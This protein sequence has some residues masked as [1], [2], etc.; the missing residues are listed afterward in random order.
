M[1]I[2]SVSILLLLVFTPRLEAQ[3]EG[4]ACT[5]CHSD[6][7]DLEM[8]HY[9]AEDA[10][11]NCH[12]DPG[13]GHP[14][15]GFPGGSLVDSLPGLCLLCH[16]AEAHEKTYRHGAQQGRGCIS[17]HDPH[18]S[19]VAGLLKKE[20]RQ[21][22]MDCH[23]GIRK[24]DRLAYRH[25]PYEDDCGNCHASHSSDFSS[26]LVDAYP[27][28]LYAPGVADTFALCFQCHD[29]ALIEEANTSWG[30]A[31]R[32]GERNLHY[33]HLQG[34]K[35]RGCSLCHTL[36]ASSLEH[37]LAGIVRFGQWD[38]PLQYTPLENGGS[39]ATAC[40]SRK[41]YARSAD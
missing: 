8:M 19:P 5:D 36:H 23:P 7:L 17:C 1:K 18:G 22:C 26:L 37:L 2:L 30:T 20:K 21:L 9:P 33:L 12:R 15:D 10:C 24:M 3:E 39:C 41:A 35:G 40:H 6:L 14:E 4:P 11:D 16:E 32:D 31:F 29:P 25:L 38:M 13:P 34:E 28:R 27:A